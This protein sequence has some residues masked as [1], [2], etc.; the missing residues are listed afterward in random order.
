M[1]HRHSCLSGDELEIEQ[2]FI[3][4]YEYIV[5]IKRWHFKNSLYYKVHRSTKTHM[6]LQCILKPICRWYLHRE[7]H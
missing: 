5:V 4:K 2:I 6:Q 7:Y 3:D 1:S